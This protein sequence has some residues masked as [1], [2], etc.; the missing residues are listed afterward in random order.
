MYKFNENELTISALQFTKADFNSN[1]FVL[2]QKKRF[3]L[4]V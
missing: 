3:L 4:Q 1:A 2:S